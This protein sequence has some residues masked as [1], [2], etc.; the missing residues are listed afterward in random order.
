M[1][2]NNAIILTAYLFLK[3]HFKE[4]DKMKKYRYRIKAEIIE[5]YKNQQKN[6]LE[7]EVIS[8]TERGAYR[9]AYS[10]IHNTMVAGGTNKKPSVVL[11]KIIER[12]LEYI[13]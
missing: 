7:L 10:K 8:T 5:G 6:Y 3:P 1:A 12:S 13:D 4:R 11:C 2:L 9:D